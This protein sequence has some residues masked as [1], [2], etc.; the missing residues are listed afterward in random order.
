MTSFPPLIQRFKATSRDGSP[1]MLCRIDPALHR[2][3]GDV[4]RYGKI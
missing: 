3:M 1:S 4:D 2:G